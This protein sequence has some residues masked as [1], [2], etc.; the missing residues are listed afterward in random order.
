[1]YKLFYF[2]SIKIVKKNLFL[3]KKLK[4]RSKKKNRK[5]NLKRRIKIIIIIRIKSFNLNIISLL[6]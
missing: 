3:I 5:K 6:Y 2:K 4:K 1:M